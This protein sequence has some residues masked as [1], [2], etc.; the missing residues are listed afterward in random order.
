MGG[1]ILFIY[2]YYY[3]IEIYNRVKIIYL[4]IIKKILN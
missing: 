4:F 1:S 2:L 3:F